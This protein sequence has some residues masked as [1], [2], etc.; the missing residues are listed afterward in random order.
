MSDLLGYIVISG[1][2]DEVNAEFVRKNMQ[3][4]KLP[5]I[6]LIGQPIIL[7]RQ[8]PL[9]SL[10]TDVWAN[11]MI[12]SIL[13]TSAAARHKLHENSHFTI[14]FG[15]KNISWRYQEFQ[16]VVIQDEEQRQH[17]ASLGKK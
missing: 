7:Q 13:I 2:Q 10:K 4:S 17:E 1:A 5:L 11:E 12:K 9:D 15:W 3:A 8:F 16:T 6:P 14:C